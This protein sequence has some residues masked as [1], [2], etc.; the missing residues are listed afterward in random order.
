MFSFSSLL[1]CSSG[2]TQEPTHTVRERALKRNFFRGKTEGGEEFVVRKK[3]LKE[4]KEAS[5]SEGG[6]M[7]GDGGR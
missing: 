1:A 6:R 5:E 3:E 4:E 2:G 7:E